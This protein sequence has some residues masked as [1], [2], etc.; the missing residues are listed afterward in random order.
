MPRF[1]LC[2]TVRKVVVELISTVIPMTILALTGPG[3]RWYGGSGLVMGRLDDP[4]VRLRA[5]EQLRAQGFG[6]RKGSAP[7]GS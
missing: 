6:D 1:T 2:R 5:L 7:S 3:A 4:A